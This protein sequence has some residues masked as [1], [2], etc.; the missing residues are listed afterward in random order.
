[1]VPEN[2]CSVTFVTCPMLM[3]LVVKNR[4]FTQGTL[5]PCAALL[6][7]RLNALG[8]KLV[9]TW[10]QTELVTFSK[11]FQTYTTHTVVF[12]HGIIVFVL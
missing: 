1:M 12:L 8:V 2:F 7:P 11:C 6:H 9:R 5:R 10:Q 4:Y 3:S